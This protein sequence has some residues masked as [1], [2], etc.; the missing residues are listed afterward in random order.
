MTND[1]LRNAL[2]VM[3]H[4]LYE[5]DRL[6]DIVADLCGAAEDVLQHA[7]YETYTKADNDCEWLKRKLQAV[8]RA[9]IP[10]RIRP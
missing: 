5:L 7:N 9:G 10:P 6:T 1:E 8:Y 4:R 2:S 3:Q